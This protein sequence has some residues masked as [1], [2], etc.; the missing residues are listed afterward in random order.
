MNYNQ[1]NNLEHRFPEIDFSEV[2][3]RLQVVPESRRMALAMKL[4]KEVSAWHS[5]G[6]YD[7]AQKI[8]VSE[9]EE[10]SHQSDLKQW[11][12]SENDSRAVPSDHFYESLLW[13]AWL[14]ARSLPDQLDWYDDLFCL[15]G[16]IAIGKDRE[17]ELWE[18]VASL[19]ESNDP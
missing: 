2:E 16:D 8:N 6:F 14:E 3:L 5:E 18:F 15:V 10:K 17:R 7:Y 19:V 13:R 11:A 12:L 9:Y 1:L 4:L